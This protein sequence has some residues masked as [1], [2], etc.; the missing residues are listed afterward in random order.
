MKKVFLFFVF[1]V[2]ITGSFALLPIL[3]PPEGAPPTVILI[4]MDGFR[5]DYWNRGK[6]PHFHELIKRGTLAD[7][8][9]PVFPSVTFT[10]H[11]SLVTGLFAENHGIVNNSMWDPVIRKSFEIHNADAAVDQSVWWE[12]EPVWVTAERQGKRT[13][14][15]F[16]VGSSAEI[17]GT[18]P[19]Y[20]MPYDQAFPKQKRIEKVLEWL[21]LP[22]EKRPQFITLY[23]E[24]TDLAGHRYGPD[25]EEV[26]Q[27]IKE[28]DDSLGLLVAGLKIRGLQKST[29]LILVSDHGMASVKRS[30]RL[31]LNDYVKPNEAKVVG[32]GAL[33]FVW[34]ASKQAELAILKKVDKKPGPFQLLLK[35]KMPERFHFSKHR[36]I[37]PLVFLANEGWY[38][39]TGLLPSIKPAVFGMH[40][41]DNI[42]PRMQAI[43]LAVGPNFNE[44]KKVGEV[45]NID[46]YSLLAHLLKLRP[47]NTD[48]SYQRIE[49]V[50][51]LKK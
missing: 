10:N 1:L 44:N 29:T 13:A 31:L 51:H 43:F 7:H 11:Y 40:G 34:P 41:Y 37:S 27:A 50:L 19:T 15:M 48:G 33:V 42:S 6:T 25:S 20:W 4:S 49:R 47:A 23:F 14:S 24:D 32:N 46:I 22:L 38:W 18:R 8:L 9:K 17:N 16:W 45:E 5:S 12:G 3:S 36:R 39:E 30:D 26:T 21:D 28:L 35:E 2:Y